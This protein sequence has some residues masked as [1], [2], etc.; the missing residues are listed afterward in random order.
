MKCP[1]CDKDASSFPYGD[2]YYRFECQCC[3]E[4]IISDPLKLTVDAKHMGKEFLENKY[5]LS[6][7]VRWNT[8]RKLELITLK[9]DNVGQYASQYK[10][11]QIR[12]KISMFLNYLKLKSKY[13]GQE[14]EICLDD[15]YPIAFC[16]HVAEFSYLLNY[17][18]ELGLVKQIA[19]QALMQIT[20]NGLEWLEKHENINVNSSKAFVAMWFDK[21]LDLA[22][23]KGIKPAISSAGY[24]PI[25]IDL[26]ETIGKVDDEIIAE[27]RQR[28]HF[29]SCKPILSSQK[30]C[31]RR[32]R[33]LEV[34][35][36]LK[37]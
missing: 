11:L 5:L 14:I 33:H 13:I 19:D 25:R 17:L 8:E 1:L 21:K 3:G 4:F 32:R 18:R 34:A 6:G 23:N 24:D 31:Y 37:M 30:M 27:I 10:N 15:D 26:K 20:P 12:D 29:V 16:K 9:T 7:A 2:T 22:Y 28:R 36:F 35:A